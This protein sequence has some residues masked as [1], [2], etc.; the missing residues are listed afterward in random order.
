[1]D[2]VT[3]S[4]GV[5]ALGYGFYTLYL[6][7]T[8]PGAFGKLDAMKTFWGERTGAAIHFLAYSLLPLAFGLIAIVSGI[9]G[10]SIFSW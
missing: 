5:A 2:A 3:I 1:M 4:V 9:R 7:R 8:R 10:V 6:R